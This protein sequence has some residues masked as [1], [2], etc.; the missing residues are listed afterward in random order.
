MRKKVDARIRTLVEN[1]VKLN[2]RTLFVV[3]GDRAREQ[4]VN[5]HY[6]LSK[7]V[8]KSRPNV[9]WCYKK[10]LYLSSHKKKRVKQI[11]KMVSRGLMDPENEDPFSLFVA[12]TDIKYTYYA[13]TQNILGNTYGMAVLQD[14]EALT[15]NL[16][17]RTVE[18]VEGG[19]IIVLLL[20]NLESLSQL[21]TLTMD[22]HSRFR[23]ESHQNVTARFN[24]R[25]ILS[26]GHCPTCI[27]MDDELNIL[28]ISSHVRDIQPVGGEISGLSDSKDLKDL[29][30]SLQETEPAGPLVGCCKTLDQAKAVVT[31]LD[32]AS[33]KTLRSTVALTA[34]RGRGKSA[35]MGIAVAGAIGMGYANVFVTSPS[36]ENLNTFFSF[37][38]KGFDALGYKEHLDYDLVE[39]SNPA[40]GK[41]IVRI[42]VTRNH[43]QTIQYILPQHHERATQAEL[44]VIDEA[45]AIPL[46]V[47][48]KLL[49]PYLVFLCSTV[50]GYEGTG[51]ALSLKLISNLRKEAA[52][53]AV[54]GGGGGGSTSARLLREVSLVEPVR[55]SFGDR[56]EG[57]LNGLLCLDAA[58]A[59]PPLIGA[60]P[61]PSAC[62]LFEVNRD[63]LFS[64]HKAS[65]LFLKRMM[66]LYIASHYKNT[67][68]DLQLMADAP[69]HRLFVLLAPVDDT[70]NALPEI[71]C[72]LQVALEGAISK[73]SASAA[74]SKGDSPQGDLVPWTVAT[75]FQD[76][77]FPMLSGVRV[78]RIAAHPD[79]PRQGYG[80]RALQQLHAYYEG[81]LTDLSETDLVP[82]DE[83]AATCEVTKPDGGLLGETIKPRAALP[84]LLS[85]L[86]EKRPEKCH[87]IASAFGL[88]QQLHKFWTRLGY[89][90]VY[91]RQT[92]SDVTGE[93][94]A[95]LI[96]MLKDSSEEGEEMNHDGNNP[97]TTPNWL[98]LFNEDFKQRFTGLLGG[99]FRDMS[100]GLA[101]AVLAP[102]VD[103]DDDQ[104]ANGCEMKSVSRANGDSITAF[105]LRRL[106]KYSQ[107]LVDHHLVADLIPPLARAYF[108]G[109]IPAT[110]SYA[111]TAIVLTIGL[112]HKEMD[113]AA[114]ELGL[115]T[116]QVMALFNK[117]VRKM[118]AALRAG[119]TR[120]VEAGMSVKHAPQLNPHAVGLDEDLE[121][122]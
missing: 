64:A 34:A 93:H 3:V 100:P 17:A 104:R 40:F 62:D 22:V 51:R 75:Q 89:H 96:R 48:Q 47:V 103:F 24:E 95:V 106:E 107:S 7:A 67:P 50:N 91:L 80:T 92:K 25:F 16:L 105:D 9:L 117:A 10:E 58:D 49:G 32:A 99:P 11:K 81:R 112:Q 44:L 4:V 30:Q 54:G 94:S 71:L 60:L 90:S 26:L 79:L 31:F 87:W 37:V 65:E 78:V 53:V 110:M 14:F 86:G 46:P 84:P 113:D 18:T 38:L 52:G 76:P 28:P 121:D 21:Y 23:T 2:E 56:V 55:Y 102:K 66:S 101:L 6:M 111:Q 59:T 13:D 85:P 8:V 19:G 122:G 114:H 36:P 74:L 1:G 41:A 12:S 118:H 97:N 33:E 61:P 5:L 15:P 116:P 120:E 42:N 68:N 72:V 57:W 82:S 20:S 109:K 45:A 83:A 35:A 98:Q 27:M 77:D 69:A 119:K 43:R 63:T 115:P 39:S 108:G 88:T 73:G 70:M 29:K